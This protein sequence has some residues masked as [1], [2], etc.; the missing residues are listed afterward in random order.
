VFL[1]HD[2][3]VLDDQTT[4]DEIAKDTLLPLQTL[5]LADGTPVQN[6]GA[7]RADES[8]RIISYQPEHVTLAV[9]AQTD[10]YVLLADTWF[11]GWVARVDSVE[12]PIQRGDYIFR[13]VRVSAGTHQIEME[14]RPLSLYLGVAIGLGAL[15]VLG[16][17]WRLN[18]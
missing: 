2:A 15:I 16:A 11:P 9:Q 6:G 13:A 18:R 17:V 4:L 1:V 7:Q 5:F 12:S 3:R 14:Y 10:G 8:V